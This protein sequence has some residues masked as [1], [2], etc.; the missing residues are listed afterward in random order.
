[1]KS[2][3]KRG[4]TLIELVMTLSIAG[5]VIFVIYSILIS[6]QKHYDIGKKKVYLNS[7]LSKVSYQISEELKNAT[8][9]STSFGDSKIG[10]LNE[11]IAMKKEGVANYISDGV[12]ITDIE[13]KFE[14]K[15]S[16]EMIN[17]TVIGTY[18]GL[19][20]RFNTSV[21]LN[22]ISKL[23]DQSMKT[24]LLTSRATSE[25]SDEER[26]VKK[27]A[28][29]YSKNYDIPKNYFDTGYDTKKTEA[30][31][32]GTKLA[33]EIYVYD[34][35]RRFGYLDNNSNCMFEKYINDAKNIDKDL[36]SRCKYLWNNKRKSQWDEIKKSEYYKNIIKE[37]L[38]DSTTKLELANGYNDYSS[39]KESQTVYSLGETYNSEHPPDDEHPALSQN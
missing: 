14:S 2:E 39:R 30:Y 24:M 17:Y 36:T 18:Q 5:I 15:P 16:G 37:K 7:E 19:T 10:I 9:V 29:Y 20:S 4:F 6:G 38:D 23:S 28:L 34:G 31:Q 22:N 25:L 21:L 12:I 11:Q 13:M 35:Y 32:F 33:R 27:S 1:M 8:L 26:A 3:K